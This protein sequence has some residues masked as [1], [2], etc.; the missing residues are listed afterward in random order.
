MSE[1]ILIPVASS[2]NW[3]LYAGI[4]VGVVATAGLVYLAAQII[5]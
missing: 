4:G 2:G 5:K 1:D 3:K